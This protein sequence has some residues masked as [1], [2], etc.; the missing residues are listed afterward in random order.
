MERKERERVDAIVDALDTVKIGGPDVLDVVL[1]E[2]R[3]LL[4]AE[5]VLAYCPSDRGTGWELELLKTHGFSKREELESRIRS[6]FATSP[7][8][9]AW[10]DP[11]SP[12]RDQRNRVI[13]ALGR[14]PP[15]QFEASRIYHEVF[16][17][18]AM[19][20]H[21]QLRAL[22]CEGSA[23][24]AWIGSLDPN[25]PD[26]RQVRVLSALVPALQRRLSVERRI[27]CGP[28][29][30]AA[31]HV[32][33]ERVGGAAFLLDDEGRICEANVA[34]RELCDARGDTVRR[35]LRDAVMHRATDIAFELTPLRENGTAHGYLAVARPQR[36]EALAAQVAATASRW[37]LT[38]R[39]RE[40]LGLVARGMANA[41]IAATL[42][43]AERTV[44]FHVTAIF[45]R[46]G[47]DSR[48]ALVA[49]LVRA[50]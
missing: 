8:R 47:V 41:T 6:F 33:L 14:I 3:A 22:V 35:A 21:K 18:L 19:Q 27:R 12:E 28:R 15:G 25:P 1:P 49:A 2:L 16:E 13:E 39:Q 11:V 50:S 5:G 43:I 30:E 7:G 10:Y 46:A 44:E 26:A 48:S 42:G 20:R 23:L 32:A 36:E 45:D 37:C 31:L 17:P 38:A 29:I 34:G 40:V 4:E 24:L 9:F